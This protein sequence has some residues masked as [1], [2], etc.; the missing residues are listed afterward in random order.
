M[1]A[2]LVA[3][4]VVEVRKA[5]PKDA[6]EGGW[7]CD[8]VLLVVVVVVVVVDGPAGVVIVAAWLLA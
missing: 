3:K 1:V 7:S 6:A 2:K 8:N 5:S 4:R